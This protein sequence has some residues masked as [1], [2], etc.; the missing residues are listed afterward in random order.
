[1]LKPLSTDNQG[2]Y[3][4]LASRYI[5]GKILGP[6]LYTGTRSDDPNDIVP[7][8]DHRELRGLRV[9]YGWLNNTD[10]KAKNTLDT[11]V[12]ENGRRFVRHYL[13]DFTAAMG[14][15][16]VDKKDA[17]LGHEYFVDLKPT[18]VQMATLGIY[19]PR[20]M[21]AHYPHL[22]GVGRFGFS[23]FEPKDWKPNY[24]N[25]AFDLMDRDDAF[26]AAKQVAA[27][28]DEEI[29]AVV[30]SGELSDPVAAG[31]VAKCLIERRD[32]VVRAFLAGT[33]PLDRFRVEEGRLRFT[34]LQPSSERWTIRWSTFNNQTGIATPLSAL[35][36]PDVNAA[37]AA[38]PNTEFLVA[39]VAAGAGASSVRVY[40]R[41]D[42]HSARVVGLDR[43]WGHRASMP[44]DGRQP[45]DQ[46][47]DR[48]APRKTSPGF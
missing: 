13:I 41:R 19:V 26:W 25:P 44:H 9:F 7:H 12:D 4:A 33:A 35:E 1:M 29:R 38:A 36:G 14:T 11:I 40:L 37:V 42:G 43:L 31:W 34:D 20:W 24:P 47:A 22:I 28:T 10:A 18:A 6:F 5:E 21:R 3:R 2:R 32:R 27:F 46:S 15:D 48:V 23:V 30:K 45:T 17:R 39:D 16:G 8:E